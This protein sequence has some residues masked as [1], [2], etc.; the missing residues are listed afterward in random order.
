MLLIVIPPL[1]DQ[2]EILEKEENTHLVQTPRD[3]IFLFFFT[4]WLTKTNKRTPLHVAAPLF[5]RP[6]DPHV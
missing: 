3:V 5:T 1:E 2:E 6:I 4:V